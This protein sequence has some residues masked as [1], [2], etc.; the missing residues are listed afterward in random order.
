VAT[1][2]LHLLRINARE[3]LRVPGSTREIDAVLDAADL[4][5]DDQRIAGPIE[6][7]LDAVSTI[8]DVVVRGDIRLR[9]T[10][11]CRR[12][13]TAVAGTAVVD[14][15]EVYQHEVVDEE[16]FLIEGDQLD[17]APAV[18]EYVLIELP[19]GPVCRDDCAG[20]CPVCG[21][22]R[23]EG[24]CECDTTVRDER[25]AALDDLHLDE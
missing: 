20:I 13:L 19:D 11:A 17:L 25:W 1:N 14:V 24:P 23:N 15:E 5:I 12:C 6:V 2:P 4:G 21:T 3:L 8:D 9:W 18:R 16:A 10:A 22:D 7:D